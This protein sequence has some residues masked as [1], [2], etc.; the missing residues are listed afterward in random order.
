MS[1]T[2]DQTK[3]KLCYFVPPSSLQATKTAI[4]ATNL[5]GCWETSGTGQFIPGPDS[6][7]DIGTRGKLEVLEEVRV[8]MQVLGRENVKKV[9]EVLKK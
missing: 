1:T 6:T 5:A 9:V 8:E 4:F 2:T 3:Y 7:P